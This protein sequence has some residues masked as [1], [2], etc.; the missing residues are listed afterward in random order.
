MSTISTTSRCSHSGTTARNSASCAN[1]TAAPSPS[2]ILRKARF[3]RKGR[4]VELE[5]TL[6]GPVRSSSPRTPLRRA[7]VQN[8]HNATGIH[9]GRLLRRESST[10]LACATSYV[11][12]AIAPNRAHGIGLDTADLRPRYAF[13]YGA[14]C[15]QRATECGARIRESEPWNYQRPTVR[16]PAPR[17][18]S[19]GLAD[20]TRALSI[21]R[22]V[23]WGF[24]CSSTAA[25]PAT[26][27]V[28]NDVPQT[29]A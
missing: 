19:S 28:L 16:R 12:P 29:L 14:D 7:D 27:G 11:S 25:A 2:P 22:G 15:R 21:W 24:F 1:A 18:S 5:K 4:H 8:K 9:F 26:K 17:L 20:C 10:Q 13:G 23:I 6:G 3:K